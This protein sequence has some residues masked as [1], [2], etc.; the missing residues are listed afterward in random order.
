MHMLMFCLLLCSLVSILVFWNKKMLTKHTLCYNIFLIS[1]IPCVI[2]PYKPAAHCQNA[3]TRSVSHFPIQARSSL[4]Q[5]DHTLSIIFFIPRILSPLLVVLCAREMQ[6]AQLCIFQHQ[7]ILKIQAFWDVTLCKLG[8][9]VAQ[10]VE[11][12]RYKPEGRRFDSRCCH[13]NFSL[14]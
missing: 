4:P 13:W 12:L 11:A 6:T 2:F 3:I 5:R 1:N 14:K 8:H 7:T 9:V 10:L